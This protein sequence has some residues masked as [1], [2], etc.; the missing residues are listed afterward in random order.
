MMWAPFSIA[1]LGAKGKF[2]YGAL[3]ATGM[4]T[5]NC[6]HRELADMEKP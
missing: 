5:E 4:S 2:P 6:E 3:E 1:L